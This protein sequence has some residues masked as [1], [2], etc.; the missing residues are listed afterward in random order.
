ME[1]VLS[2]LNKYNVTPHE[3]TSWLVYRLE[4][5]E[6]EIEGDISDEDPDRID[7]LFLEINK[8]NWQTT[9]K[10]DI[11]KIC[12]LGDGIRARLKR[13]EFIE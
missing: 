13:L 11:D 1:R 10:E 4:A 9:S 2:I 7:N 3:L 12:S 5:L 6:E 8:L